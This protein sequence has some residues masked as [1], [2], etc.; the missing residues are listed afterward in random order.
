MLGTCVGIYLQAIG[1][2]FIRGFHEAAGTMVGMAGMVINYASFGALIF[3]GFTVATVQS[4]LV[5]CYLELMAVVVFLLIGMK[6]LEY[7]ARDNEALQAQLEK[8]LATT[9]VCIVQLRICI[10]SSD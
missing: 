10:T 7:Y 9:K 6:I 2:V 8:C 4:V 3:F 1:F 5:E